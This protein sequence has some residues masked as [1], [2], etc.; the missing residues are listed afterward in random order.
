MHLASSYPLYCAEAL[1]R[2]YYYPSPYVTP[3][4]KYD[5]LNGGSSY[6]S[7]SGFITNRFSIDATVTTTMDGNYS[8]GSG[9][10]NIHLRNDTTV[11]ITG[12]VYIVITEDSLYYLG[13]NG[14]PWHNHVARDYVPTDAGQYVSIPAGDSVTVSQPFTIQT[15]WNED[16]CEIVAWLQT[17]GTRKVWQGATKQVMELNPG[18]EEHEVEV[19]S[20]YA[21]TAAPNPCVSGTNFSFS[22]PAGVEYGI[23]IF[24]VTGRHVKTLCGIS[25]GSQEVVA[26]NLE[27]D[28]GMLVG[29]GVYLYQF[30]SSTVNTTGKIV[31]R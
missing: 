5:G 8:D 1:S 22:L 6:G 25:S 24:D 28:T 31:V 15:G 18:I 11:T 13:P 12:R 23:N 4:L 14:D 26:W 30:E 29:S 20:I 3:M 19:A 10:I 9:T 21:V 27:D 2:A 7:W 17:D 16:M